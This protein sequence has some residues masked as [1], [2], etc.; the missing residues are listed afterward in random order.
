MKFGKYIE[1]SVNN[2]TVNRFANTLYITISS[3]NTRSNLIYTIHGPVV[4]NALAM[5]EKIM[6]LYSITKGNVKSRNN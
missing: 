5:A 1:Q 3:V 6:S 2:H 4:I